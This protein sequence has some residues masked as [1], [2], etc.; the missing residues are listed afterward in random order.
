MLK[1]VPESL[2]I[3]LHEELNVMQAYGA[4]MNDLRFITQCG[5]G[6]FGCRGNTASCQ[7]I[8]GSMQAQ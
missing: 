5:Q 6:Q 7:T 3:M 4:A 2:R 8:K 1:D